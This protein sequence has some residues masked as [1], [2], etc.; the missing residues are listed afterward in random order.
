M[1][2]KIITK[3][4]LARELCF[5]RA[6]IS[7][8]CQ[9]GLPVRPDGKLNRAEALVWVETYNSPWRG[10]WG[11]S[12]VRDGRR[13]RAPMPEVSI[14]GDIDLEQ[15]LSELGDFAENALKDLR[16]TIPDL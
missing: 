9:K 3:A 2:K 5:S 14:V 7:Q 10:G 8:L 11:Y 4:E 1:A 15:L 12:T 6:R 13:Q 16:E